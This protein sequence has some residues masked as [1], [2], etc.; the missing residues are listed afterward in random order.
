[1][2][3]FPILPLF[4]GGLLSQTLVFAQPK[5]VQKPNI[6]LIMA[7]DLGW[8]DVGFNGNTIIRTPALDQMAS[9]GLVFD[10]FYADFQTPLEVEGAWYF[11]LNLSL[12]T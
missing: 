1:M 11:E 5:V 12:S 6:I 3:I 8:G 4:F 7:D 9:D 10:R 2:K